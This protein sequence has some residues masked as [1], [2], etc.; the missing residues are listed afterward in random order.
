VP[1][2]HVGCK[3]K[4]ILYVDRIEIFFGGK[5]LAVHARLYANNKWSL[6]PE[7]Y[8]ELI[9]E[10]PMSFNSARPI[11][12]WREHWPE[13]LHRLLASF[14][15]HQGETKGIKDFISVLMLYGQY[16][17]SEVE[18]AVELA[19][20]KNIHASDGLQHILLYA[21]EVIDPIAPLANWTSLPSPD[22]AVYG[23]LGG[24]L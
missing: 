7:H 18:T 15:S 14:C 1:W 17:S 20:E 12:Q 9:Q 24:V 16:S 23:A 13:S 10:R 5:R 8:L 21:N 6:I 3:L 2:R 19:L 22:L 11:K 4:V